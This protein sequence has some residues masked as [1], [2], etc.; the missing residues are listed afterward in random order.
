VYS[1]ISRYRAFWLLTTVG[2]RAVYT[3]KTYAILL[4]PRE[5]NRMICRRT[6]YAWCR[7]SQSPLV[8]LILVFL[9]W[10]NRRVTNRFCI[11]IW[12]HCLTSGRSV[13]QAWVCPRTPLF[14]VT[15]LATLCIKGLMID[16]SC[17][18]R[19]QVQL[20]D[21]TRSSVTTLAGVSQQDG[22]VME[23]TTVVTCLTNSTVAAPPHRRVAYT[24]HYSLA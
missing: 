9:A 3:G 13:A 12:C 7:T 4:M 2:L 19:L 18:C 20:V 22:S 1:T 21:R 15:I 8:P 17:N 10:T 23:T 14:Y 11:C 5:W 16:T 24:D 6:V